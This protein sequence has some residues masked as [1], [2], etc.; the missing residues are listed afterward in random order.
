M[1][2]MKKMFGDI[3]QLHPELSLHI[4]SDQVSNKQVQ[5]NRR[6]I[7]ATEFGMSWSLDD[8]VEPQFVAIEESPPKKSCIDR[9]SNRRCVP[10][11]QSDGVVDTRASSQLDAN[12]CVATCKLFDFDPSESLAAM[13]VVDRSVSSPSD[14]TSA[15]AASNTDAA[16]VYS[17][18]LQRMRPAVRSK[19]LKMLLDFATKSGRRCSSDDGINPTL[20]KLATEIES[21]VAEAFA[22]D[23][24]EYINKARSIVFNLKYSR[25][26]TF[27]SK[28]IE[29]IL[30]PS[31][32]PS[33]TAD[34]MASADLQSERVK[35]R[36]EAMEEVQAD[37][38]LKHGAA[39]IKGLFTCRHCE[40]TKT[41]YFQLQTRSADEPMTTFVGCLTCGKRWKC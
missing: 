18:A 20:E 2:S 13:L 19:L 25:N 41:T 5:P 17:R 23:E 33:L 40:G 28:I 31:M 11:P 16:V 37:W 39:D 9:D 12:G 8:S 26:I 29:G 10:I 7:A 34:E 38:D 32:I 30:P 1:G 22:T 36:R 6:Q 15:C 3:K 14:D 27:G 4:T 35:V 24:K 21:S